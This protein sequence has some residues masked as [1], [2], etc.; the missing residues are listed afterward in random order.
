[1]SNNDIIHNSDD[2]L[3]DLDLGDFDFTPDEDLLGVDS[4][5][6]VATQHSNFSEKPPRTSTS[7]TQEM[8][9]V[10]S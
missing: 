8:C 7:S 3:G 9:V 1:M 10:S 4:G 2:D 5:R 6:L